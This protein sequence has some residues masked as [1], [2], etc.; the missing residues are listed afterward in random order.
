MPSKVKYYYYRIYDDHEEFNYIKS[1][2]PE[3]KIRSLL[4][5]FEKKNDMYY[6]EQFILFLKQHDSKAELIS[7]NTISY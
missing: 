6:N 4:K 3:K 7:V 5:K 2:L 1:A